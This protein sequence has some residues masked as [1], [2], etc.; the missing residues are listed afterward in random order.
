MFFK[1]YLKFIIIGICIVLLA[2]AT[3]EK[4]ENEYNIIYPSEDEIKSTLVSKQYF[5]FFKLMDAQARNI[6][7]DFQDFSEKYTSS[8]IPL[9]EKEKDKFNIFYKNIVNSI[10]IKKR[11][12]LLISNLKIAKFSNIENDFPHTHNDII[13]LSQ[14]FIDNL[15][16]ESHR[17]TLIHEICHIRQRQ[18]PIMYDQLFNQWGFNSISLE[19]MKQHFSKDIINRIRINPDEL[20]DYRFWV[21]NQKI[22]PLV[23]YSS[24]KTTNINDVKY[25]AFNWKDKKTYDILESNGEYNTYFNI[26]VNHYHPNEIL[27]EYYSKYYLEVIGQ[28]TLQDT[29]A[30]DKFKTFINN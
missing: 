10:P 13:F 24:F 23:I 5:S 1:I 17:K 28:G 14:S 7:L 11:H 21:W 2:Y 16:T 30:Y 22:V 12:I 29:E 18:F 25:I 3:I 6:K 4:F 27:A 15:D 8:I 9:T 20:P 26:G 19:Y